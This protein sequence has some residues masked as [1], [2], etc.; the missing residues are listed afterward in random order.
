MLAL[1][2]VAVLLIVLFGGLAVFVAKA[3]FVALIVVA[4]LALFGGYRFRSGRA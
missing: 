4:I 2:L 3:F 1:F